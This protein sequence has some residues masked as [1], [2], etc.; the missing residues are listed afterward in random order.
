[1][2]KVKKPVWKYF[3]V[4]SNDKNP[5]PHVKCKYCPKDF[6]RAVPK[7]MQAHLDKCEVA[8]NYAKSQ[9]K[10]QNATNNNYSDRM[11]IEEQKHLEFLLEKAS[12]ILSSHSLGYNYQQNFNGNCEPDPFSFIGYQ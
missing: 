5:H 12:R 7:R 10:P 11:S 8:P 1:M 4:I 3:D 9:P 6:R 2:P